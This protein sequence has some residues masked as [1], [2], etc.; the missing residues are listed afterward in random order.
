MTASSFMMGPPLYVQKFG[1]ASKIPEFILPTTWWWIHR[2][3]PWCLKVEFW[4]SQAS[5]QWISRVCCRLRNVFCP[6]ATVD[7]T[8]WSREGVFS[9]PKHIQFFKVNQVAGE[10]NFVEGIVSRWILPKEKSFPGLKM[11]QENS[12]EKYLRFTLLPRFLF[13]K[14]GYCP[15][16]PSGYARWIPA[17]TT[18]TRWSWRNWRSFEAPAA[19]KFSSQWET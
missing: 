12:P 18:N 9:I 17:T 1:Q 15:C 2:S 7:S 5:N 16:F 19:S 3:P 11:N 10:A 14:V 4:G 8:V 13:G 6:N